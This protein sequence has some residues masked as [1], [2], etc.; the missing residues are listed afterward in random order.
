MRRDA[1]ERVP[2]AQGL[3]D[4]SYLE[5]FEVAESAVGELA[6]PRARAPAK[7]SLLEKHHGKP[8]GRSVPW[9]TCAILPAAESMTP[10]PTLT[11]DP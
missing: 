7:V 9:A 8:A 10:K 6:G 2:L 4:Q 5:V 11:P 1:Q 3:A